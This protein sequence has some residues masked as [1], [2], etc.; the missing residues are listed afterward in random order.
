MRLLY[1]LIVFTLA[2]CGG[3]LNDDQRKQMKEAREL[4]SI[5]KVSEAEITE[6]A[7]LQGRD[8]MK[9][10]RQAPNAI[11]SLEAEYQVRISW[12]TPGSP[13]GTEIERQLIDAYLNSMLTGSA[14]TDN[15]QKLAEDS[16]LYSQP[17][18]RELP[19]GTVAVDGVWNISIPTKQVV[20]AIEK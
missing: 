3:S 10:I 5:K 17:V 8:I 6:M 14:L 20:L 2:G 15:V 4:K 11:D 12:L 18:T 16:L 7:F 19:D 13:G 1:F 9:A